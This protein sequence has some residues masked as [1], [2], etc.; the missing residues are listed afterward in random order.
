MEPVLLGTALALGAI[1]TFEAD[2]MAAVSAFVVR[3]PRILDALGYG[4]RWAVGH[5]GVILVVGTALILFRIHLPES[6]GVALERLVGVSLIVL[7]GWV[8]LTARRLHAHLHSHGDTV[9]AHL[10][11]H[12]VPHA[13]ARHAPVVESPPPVHAHGHAATAMGALHGLAGTAP[14]VALVPLAGMDSTGPAF[15]YLA[16]FGLGTALSMGLFA[17][18]AGWAA[19]RMTHRSG[20]VGRGLARVAGLGSVA[21][22]ILWLV[23]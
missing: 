13:A 5:G 7:G 14:A 11:A 4:L 21:V 15:V 23:G 17:M 3:R 20:A 16:V 10:H 6:A 8:F 18:F 1:H 2:H 12:P 19:G 22:G 9:H